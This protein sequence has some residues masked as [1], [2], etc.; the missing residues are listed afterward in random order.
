MRIADAVVA[1]ADSLAALAHEETGLGLPRLDG[2][3]LR[4]ANQLRFYADVCIEGSWLGAT[5][6][7]AT[8]TTPD[9]R[10]IQAS[11]GPVAVF[12]ASNFPFGFGTLGTTPAPPSPPGLPS[13]S[14]DT[15]P[16]RARMPP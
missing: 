3:V 13:W 6:D 8:A 7:H 14:K 1:H 15:Q 10:R 11:V 16:T 12:G 2:E 5:I 4:C 9:L